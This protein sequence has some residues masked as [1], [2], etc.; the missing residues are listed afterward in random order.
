MFVDGGTRNFNAVETLSVHCT[1]EN[2]KDMGG[3][4]FMQQLQSDSDRSKVHLFSSSV[5]CRPLDY[6]GMVACVVYQHGFNAETSRVQWV[7]KP[8]F[9]PCYKVKAK[10]KEE[11]CTALLLGTVPLFDKFRPRIFAS[12][13]S[14]CSALSST[15][16]PRLKKSF[17]TDPQGLPL[18]SFTEELF[19]QL[20]ESRPQLLDPA[21]AAYTVA[22][23]QDL[24][25]QIDFNGD[26]FV[27]WDEFT[28]FCIH[29]GL[30]NRS[31]EGSSQ[32]AAAS[33]ENLNQYTI[34]YAANLDVV[35]TTLTS[36]LT[37]HQVRHV[38]ETRRVLV[39][40]EAGHELMVFDENFHHL[41]SITPD[42]VCKSLC[43]A[44]RDE[45]IRIYDVC[46]IPYKDMYAYTASDHTIVV[47][48]EHSTVGGRRLHYTLFNKM[49]HQ[50][51]QLK[52]C[53][54]ERN[55]LL[56]SVDS[57]NMIYG[58]E[59]DGTIPIFQLNRH[60]ELVTDFI[61]ID[62]HQLFVT[63]S[64]DKRIV[65]WSQTSRRVKGVLLGHTRGVRC[66]SYAKDTLLSAGFECDAKTWDL[67]TKEPAL[68]LRGHRFPICCA[69]IMCRSQSLEDA[70]NLRAITVDDSGEFRLWN[71]YVKEKSSDLGYAE[72]L[73]VFVGQDEAKTAQ[74]SFIFFPFN[75]R[76]SCDKYSNVIGASSKLLH[77][78]PEK[79][80]KEFISPSCLVFSETNAA[81]LTAVGKSIV[82]YDVVN[83]GFHC[84]FDELDN[85]EICSLCC[86]GQHGR[87]LYAGMT[88]GEIMVINF[89]TGQ[90]ISKS[91]VHSK[92]VTCLTVLTNKESHTVFSA[93]LDGG[94]KALTEVGGALNV[95]FMLENALGDY[96]A[97][98]HLK[99]IPAHRLIMASSVNRSWGVWGSFALKKIV[100][101]QETENISGL[102]VVHMGSDVFRSGYLEEYTST[103]VVIAVCLSNSIKIYAIDFEYNKLVHSH[104]LLSPDS[105]YLSRLIALSYPKF[106]SVN[107]G[108]TNN[109]IY[110]ELDHVLVAS[111]DEGKLVVW[112]LVGIGLEAVEAY[113]SAY[114][115]K[116]LK[117]EMRLPGK[118]QE[119]A[120]VIKRRK[121]DQRKSLR[122]SRIGT[123]RSLS[124]FRGLTLSTK[125]LSAH[126]ADS[127]DISDTNTND[128]GSLQARRVSSL[129]R[130]PSSSLMSQGSICE[131]DD[132]DNEVEGV[133][134]KACKVLPASIVWQAHTDLIQSL[135]PLKEHN[136]FI[137]MSLDGY[138]RIWNLQE[139]CVGELPLPNIADKRKQLNRGAPVVK[140]PLSWNFVM[141]KMP[142]TWEHRSIASALIKMIKKD[143]S[144]QRKHSAAQEYYHRRFQAELRQSQQEEA[145]GAVDEDED[146]A[147]FRRRSVM[148][149]LSRPYTPTEEKGRTFSFSNSGSGFGSGSTVGGE[150]Q[151]CVS[152][153]G[154][155]VP[156]PF[157]VA[158]AKAKKDKTSGRGSS[159]ASNA[160]SL[161]RSLPTPLS[162][163]IPGTA[164]SS[165]STASA[166]RPKTTPLHSNARSLY[167]VQEPWN[168]IQDLQANRV[169]AFSDSSINASHT[170]G[171]IDK[172]AHTILRR[173]NDD[174]NRVVVYDRTQPSIHLR[175]V[176]K[177]CT[178]KYPGGQTDSA[179]VS[180]GTQKN[181]YKN[182][183]TIMRS[184]AQSRPTSVSIAR[185]NVAIARISNNV[186]HAG[187]MVQC[188]THTAHGDVIL[189]PL[190]TENEG[191]GGKDGAPTPP[192][193]VQVLQRSRS[194][195]LRRNAS[196][197]LV[198]FEEKKVLDKERVAHM[199]QKVVDATDQATPEWEKKL[200]IKKRALRRTR[201]QQKT[202]RYNNAH[203]MLLLLERKLK[204]AMMSAHQG[205][206]SDTMQ[207]RQNLT[208]RDLLP[209]YQIMDLKNFL[210]IFHAVDDDFSGDLNVEEWLVFFAAFN[211]SMTTHQARVMFTKLDDDGDGFLSLRDLIPVIFSRASKEQMT[212]I[213][214]YL[215]AEVCT[216][217][218]VTKMEYIQKDELETM[219]TY[220]DV[221]L[222]GFVEV[223]KIKDKIRSFQM[224]DQAHLAIF[225]MFM[226]Y[227]DD[228]MVGLPEFLKLFH[229]YMQV[230]KKDGPPSPGKV[231]NHLKPTTQESPR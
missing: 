201:S 90:T 197:G 165:R 177:A 228:E 200:D 157:D 19:V 100:V 189:P 125:D 198:R 141:E 104:T 72:L 136:C 93:S 149:E 219:F 130:K 51:L 191:S 194:M 156:N 35:D 222:I 158:D 131:D 212:L 186:T 120:G 208:S 57:E 4:S 69:K 42:K 55:Q 132:D 173:L 150:G 50:N 172:E 179:E 1:Q 110:L 183:S 153:S 52:L 135:V 77:Y 71:I 174:K 44:D 148:S 48:K 199:I 116:L 151:F 96:A 7:C 207:V 23:L 210:E 138:I 85:G 26:G 227:E 38:P 31:D 79:I 115:D 3:L 142:V 140:R 160:A 137:T 126:S 203:D 223:K 46:Y 62:A 36:Y 76:Y 211:K 220:Y 86:D 144:N 206:D 80:K 134:Q 101:Q 166:Q 113:F 91:L 40:E 74:I 8:L 231:V 109:P 78:R 102:E 188:V 204:Y 97:I 9:D 114:P 18:A 28:T 103:I 184:K 147:T 196:S 175:N 87:R 37:L 111:S 15:A 163:S 217:K 195:G 133:V 187:K 122:L 152:E 224:P 54:S 10:E 213:S 14:I 221:D 182:A 159:A 84:E 58:W 229:P 171:V 139:E 17:V 99:A 105:L 209:F 16:L 215:E 170:Q 81:I 32:S 164:N 107:Y 65:L 41:S 128:D 230:L 127:E 34:E 75:S 88:N 185:H 6:E 95:H 124:S 59:L 218:E 98:I 112:N 29:T 68:L 119:E 106:N 70:D 180:F 25:G 12:V 89:S 94:I 181:M 108:A 11:Y 202:D 73:Q 162:L 64:L 22:L 192:K 168:N 145:S 83:G 66:I 214:K 225:A 226:G 67:T 205:V 56:C 43:K 92:D 63:C 155:N 167:R 45:Q 5:E 178:M 123:M 47:F 60:T 190:L 53:W 39:L 33:L 61:A 27:D 118:S 176:N 24:F 129:F 121:A 161:S 13:K 216:K 30:V 20:H 143:S 117:L 146:D 193:K 82:K 169:A 49:F 154:D 21:E 2:L